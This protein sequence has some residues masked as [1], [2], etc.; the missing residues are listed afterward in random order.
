MTSLEKTYLVSLLSRLSGIGR[1]KNKDGCYVYSHRTLD[2]NQVFYVGISSTLNF[3]RAY[4]TTYRS[5]HWNNIVKKHGYEI[6]ILTNN[7]TWEEVCELE[8]LLI[9][10][11]GRKDLGLGNLCNLTDGGEG[12]FGVIR[13]E[14]LRK[15]YGSWN[16]GRKPTEEHLQKNREANSGEKNSFYKKSHP[17]ELVEQ[18]RQKNIGRKASEETRAL[19]RSQRT[20]DKHSAS[21]LVLCLETGI[22][23]DSAKDASFVFGI[24]HST[25][26]SRLN[27]TVKN[28]TNLIYC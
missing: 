23:Y 4:S 15:K 14:E 25:L 6:Q 16:I 9:K 8:K 10:Y 21:K 22:F 26:K 18:I 7:K 20:S 3:K 28:K 2:T 17:P 19:L 13:S 24:K 27:G 11:Y 5:K 1:M 12:T